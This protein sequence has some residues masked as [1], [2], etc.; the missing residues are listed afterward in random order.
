MIGNHSEDSLKKY[1]CRNPILARVLAIYPITHNDIVC[2]WNSLIVGCDAMIKKSLL[3][4]NQKFP[5]TNYFPVLF[6]ILLG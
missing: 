5:L 2:D 3:C 6:L 4:Q 1:I